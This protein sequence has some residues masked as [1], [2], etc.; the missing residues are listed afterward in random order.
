M[1]TYGAASR[2]ALAVFAGLLA[3]TGVTTVGVVAGAAS[4]I[5][6]AAWWALNGRRARPLYMSA[7]SAADALDNLDTV[8][9]Q[10]ASGK[11][12]QP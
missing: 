2:V 6:G 4:V 7:T 8:S 1:T 12:C 9:S 10:T 5:V 11:T 3:V